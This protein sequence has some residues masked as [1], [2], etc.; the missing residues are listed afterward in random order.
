MNS[1]DYLDIVIDGEMF[2][3]WME[4]SEELGQVIIM[5]DGAGYHQKAASVR[6]KQLEKDG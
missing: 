1:K 3:F 4:S 2:D 5:E 6:R